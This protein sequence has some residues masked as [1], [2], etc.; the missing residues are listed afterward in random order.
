MYFLTIETSCDETSIAFFK[1][2]KILNHYIYSQ[3][4]EH[5]K[6]KGVVPEIASR[7]HSQKIDELIKKINIRKLDYVGFTRGPGLTGSLLIGK[8]AALTIANYFN[9]KVVGINHLEG[10]ILSCEIEKNIIKKKLKFP[11]IALI[12]SGGHSELWYVY[13]YGRYKKIGSTRDDACGE[14]FDKVAKVMGLGYPGGSVIEK[15]AG[16]C[17]KRSLKFTVP[18]VKNSFDYSFSGIKTQIAYYVKDI[19]ALSL[20]QKKEIAYAFQ[21]AVFES[22]IRKLELA[23]LKYKV[24]NIVLGGGVCA[25][26]ELRRIVSDKFSKMN[27]R[28]YLPDK[29]YTS[30]NAAMLG[31]CLLRRIEKG[32]FKNSIEI[33]SDLEI[34]SW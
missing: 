19:K 23:C 7:Q 21:N 10:H 2:N 32:G 33:D 15:L 18:D 3:I 14:A 1:N 12:V 25:N 5:K 9:S 28:V 13:D 11:L 22:I 17:R 30:D 6:Y 24:S 8:I 34:E 31:V 29:L 26:N 4:K 20:S 27:I 16:I